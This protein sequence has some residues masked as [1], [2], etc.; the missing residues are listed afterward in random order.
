ML[1]VTEKAAA[2]LSESL[3]A[4]RENDSDVLRLT[5]AA[6]GMGLALDQE[7]EGDQVIEHEDRKVLVVDP[8]VADAL[9]GTTIDIVDT[10]E[11]QRL[12]VQS[13]EGN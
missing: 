11:G 6:G 9:D 13:D 2:A 3:D 4:N 8:E 5:Q 10:P 1:N 7:H 12:V